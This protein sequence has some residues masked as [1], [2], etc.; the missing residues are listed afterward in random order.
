VWI[1]LIFIGIAEWFHYICSNHVSSSGIVVRRLLKRRRSG[2]MIVISNVQTYAT[3][4]TY[5]SR[6]S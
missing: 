4:M 6:S 5:Y 2:H 3:C 1:L